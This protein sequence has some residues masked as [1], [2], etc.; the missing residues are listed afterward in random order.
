MKT[1]YVT[2][3]F[4]VN[5]AAAGAWSATAEA[6]ACSIDIQCGGCASASSAM[7]CSHKS[8]AGTCVAAST[9]DPGYCNYRNVMPTPQGQSD[10][11]PDCAC[12]GIFGF[13]ICD[14]PTHRCK[15]TTIESCNA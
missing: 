15:C 4:A 10:A 14:I 1:H 2:A 6:A 7:V 9:G 13:G 11:D 8:S 12:D 5:V 3:L